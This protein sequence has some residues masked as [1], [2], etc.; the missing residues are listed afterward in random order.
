MRKL[1]VFS[2]LLALLATAAFAELAI[3][4]EAQVGTDLVYFIKGTQKITETGEETRNYGKLDKG[5]FNFYSGKNDVW[6]P[7][8]ALRLTFTHTT[9]NTEAS[10][11]LKAD[12]VLKAAMAGGG[13]WEDILTLG[14]F[15]DWYFQ[16]TLNFL[17]AY[18]GNTGYGGKVDSFDNFNDFVNW[19]EY[20][21]ALGG[22]GVWKG[23]GSSLD[24]WAGSNGIDAFGSEIFAL[25]LTFGNFK[26]A[27]GTN[28]NWEA[29]QVPFGSKAAANGAFIFSGDKIADMISFD[30]FYAFQGKDDDTLHRKTGEWDH[31]F[32]VY[33]GLTLNDNLGFSLGYTGNVTA[34]EADERT[35]PN[36]ADPTKPKKIAV[37][38]TNPFYSGIDLHVN[39]AFDKLGITFNNNVSFAGVK[40]IEK[41]GTDKWVYGLS[42]APL[43]Q[44]VS[45]NWF[46]YSSGLLVSY[47]LSD[48]FALAFQVAD[49]VG[50]FTYKEKVG[51]VSSTSTN[52]INELR[53]ALSCEYT[54]SFAKFGLG[55]NFGLSSLTDK[56]EASGGGVSHTMTNSV[57]FISFGIPMYFKVSF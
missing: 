13:T 38:V 56:T 10:V 15:G 26:F 46:A 47:N 8:A 9:E 31:L 23:P 43:G 33:A 42:G 1:L 32:G 4:F 50:V 25:G 6:G 5:S 12:D 45:E 22:F 39:V 53:I 3:G 44:D 29:Y 55:L 41:N 36:A 35:E 16:G 30:A 28:L 14:L 11:Q 49:K 7:G 51:D 24:A 40:G 2:V 20:F 19:D 48:N 52:T 21:N 34:T 37:P 54:V 17:D 27:A 18:V 57:N